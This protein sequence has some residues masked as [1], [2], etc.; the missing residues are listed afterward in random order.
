LS[1]VTPNKVSFS[2]NN[3]P[4]GVKLASVSSTAHG[5]PSEP[6]RVACVLPYVKLPTVDFPSVPAFSIL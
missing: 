3:P 6:L 2:I 1:S 5:W 4:P